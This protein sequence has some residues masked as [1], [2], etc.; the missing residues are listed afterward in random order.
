MRAEAY[1]EASRILNKELP[2]AWLWNE[3]RP[4]AFNNRIVGL[5][6]HFKEQPLVIFNHAVYNEVEKW[7]VAK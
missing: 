2:K 5:A 3:V 4:L 1:Q 6:Q 7:E